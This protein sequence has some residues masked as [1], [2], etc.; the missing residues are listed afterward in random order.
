MLILLL[1][2]IYCR[3]TSISYLGEKI[4]YAIVLS[5]PE[6]GILKLGI[7]Q[8]T[9]D[10]TIEMLG[11]PGLHLP[12]K[13]GVTLNVTFPKIPITIQPSSDAWVIKM[14]NLRNP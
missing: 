13:A 9:S 5:W 6:S 2:F 8:S 7:P 1:F 11:L 12:Y 3:Y 10:T 14:K 4:V